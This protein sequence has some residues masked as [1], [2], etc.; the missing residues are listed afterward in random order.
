MIQIR[1]SHPEWVNEFIQSIEPYKAKVVNSRI[2]KEMSRGTLDSKRFRGGL[3][4]FYPLIENFP[5]YMALNLAKV[6]AGDSPWNKKTR[7]WLITNINQERLHTV[8]WKQW[9]VGFGVP[10]EAL[11][12]EIRPPL[13]MDAINN[14]L[15]RVCTHGSL[16]EGISAA[17][18]AIEGA[19]G[20]WTK[21]VKEDLKKYERVKG[22]EVNKRTL[23]W[24]TAHA[25]YDDR[26]P[27]EALEVIKA[28]A[29]TN[30]EREKVRQAAQR[31][32]E[33]YALALDACYEIFSN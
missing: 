5:L 27:D 9:A 8:W 22:A 10:K 14:Y 31:S 17:N 13:E 18:Y 26:H 11:D 33:Y 23:R 32:L 24:V 7:Y 21:K 12:K 3:I 30:E 19:T 16:S 6:P 28:Y 1:H 20:E 2:F 29:T 25:S 4:N 15:W